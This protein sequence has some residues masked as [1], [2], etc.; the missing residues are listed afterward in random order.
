MDLGA[1]ELMDVKSRND[2]PEGAEYAHG[3]ARVC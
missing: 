3:R 2:L 1:E